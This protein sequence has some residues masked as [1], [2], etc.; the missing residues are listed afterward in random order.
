[1][2]LLLLEDDPMLGEGLRD[3]LRADG[4]VVDCACV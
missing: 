2:R 4:H 1:V 3:Y